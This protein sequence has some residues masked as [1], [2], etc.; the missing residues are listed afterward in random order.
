MSNVE[1]GRKLDGL[2]G[3]VERLEPE[4]ARVLGYFRV[5]AQDG[6][7]ILQDVLLL[8]LTRTYEIRTP[9]AWLVGTL[10]MRCRIYWRK[11]RRRLLDTI[12]ETLLTELAGPVAP[13]QERENITRDLSKAIRRLPERCRSLIQLRYGLGCDDPEVAASLGYSSNSIRKIASRCLSALTVQILSHERH[14][15]MGEVGPKDERHEL[16]VGL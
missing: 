1:Q 4:F 15:Q 3:L 6:E 2:T 5:P 12:D 9:D 11:R 8:F 16:P 10:R 14:H 13:S 7:D